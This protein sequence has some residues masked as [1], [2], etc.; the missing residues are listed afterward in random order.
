MDDVLDVIA[1]GEIIWSMYVLSAYDALVFLI[2]DP[3][4][5]VEPGMDTYSASDG[6]SFATPLASGYVALILSRMPNATLEQVRAIIRSNALDLIDPNGVGQNLPGYDPYSGFGRVRMVIPF[7]AP[8]SFDLSPANASSP[9]GTLQTFTATYRDSN[10]YEDIAY[11]SIRIGNS[12]LAAAYLPSINRLYLLNDE[13][14]RWIG[15]YPPGS[16]NAIRNRQGLLDCQSTTVSISGDTFT[17][18]WSFI[19]DGSWAG[20][21][22]KVYLLAEDKSGER[23]GWEQK[24]TW[25]V[26]ENQGNFVRGRQRFSPKAPHELAVTNLT[27]VPANPKVGS[28]MTVQ[29]TIANLG[30]NPER[31]LR[32]RLSV[33]NLVWFVERINY[34]GPGLSADGRYTLKA[35]PPPGIYNLRAEIL[36]IPMESNKA[37]NTLI[38]SVFVQR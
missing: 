18:N 25:A 9:V 24:G 3:T 27:V 16:P 28:N 4:L 12:L 14:N 31:N 15:G 33:N 34:I 36:P 6:T 17:V 21:T 11:A 22:Q 2:L 19:P 20:T 13:G 26:L 35:Y 7:N 8:P 29:V 5:E 10:G 23:V 30:R 38:R 37:N 1:P 32:F